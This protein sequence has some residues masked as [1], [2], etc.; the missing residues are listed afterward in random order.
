M[1]KNLI[2][3]VLLITAITSGCTAPSKTSEVSPVN[4]T[5]GLENKLPDDA[6]L[7]EH[8]AGMDFLTKEERQRL[9]EAEKE[10]DPIYDE[11]EKLSTQAEEIRIQLEAK[12]ESEFTEKETALQ[13]QEE[14]LY[15]Q[16]DALYDKIQTI[17]EKN[18]D[19]WE[20][21]SE[22]AEPIVIPYK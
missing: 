15:Q 9:I 10:K 18:G 19:L 4:S 7:E 5:P 13:D 8:L 3:G 2:L 17:D 11:I 21:I 1:K 6:T 16:M 14:N 20:K 12:K 22:N